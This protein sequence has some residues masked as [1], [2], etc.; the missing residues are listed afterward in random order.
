MSFMDV[1]QGTSVKQKLE[2]LK[3]KRVKVALKFILYYI[4]ID[5]FLGHHK[6]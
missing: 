2:T 4:Y 6:T 1:L 5:R 3:P